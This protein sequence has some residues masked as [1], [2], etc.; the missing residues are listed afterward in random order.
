MCLFSKPTYIDITS[1]NENPIWSVPVREI[2]SREVVLRVGDSCQAILYVD[3]A[4]RIFHPG[5]ATLAWKKDFYGK[6][7]TLI[8]VNLEKKFT[9]K[10]G[11]G[12][13]PFRDWETDESVEVGVRGECDVTILDAKAI[14]NLFGNGVDK[15]SVD[16]VRNGILAKMQEYLKSNLSEMLMGCSYTEVN[17][18][19]GDFSNKLL[20]AFKTEFSKDGLNISRCSIVAIAF[21]EGYAE[22]RIEVL[23]GKRDEEDRKKQREDEGELIKAIIGQS[24]E[25]KSEAPA[26]RYCPRCGAENPAGTRYCSQCGIKLD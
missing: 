14:V 11:A 18:M 17:S 13:V 20:N 25:P 4:H 10:F 7:V 24:S 19:I 6:A 26:K 5:K 2:K 23:Q 8:G 12:G 3:G 1:A 16:D 9:I 22:H 15:I 21:P